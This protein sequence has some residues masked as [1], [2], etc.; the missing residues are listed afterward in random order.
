MVFLTKLLAFFQELFGSM[1]G[2]SSPEFKKKQAFK[3]LK[4]LIRQVDPPLYRFDGYLLP[5]FPASLQQVY[6]FLVPIKEI[7]DKTIG[8]SEE[9]V[10]CR[11]VDFLIELSLPKE[12]R[13][14]AESLSLQARMDSLI[15]SKLDPERV[16]EE[17]A[18]K[19]NAY[20][21]YIDSSSMKNVDIVITKM[22]CLKDL[23]EFDFNRFF[24]AFDPAFQAH[25]GKT[26][27]VDSPQFK[28]V[29]VTEVIPDLLDLYYLLH[30]LDLNQGVANILVLL[31]AQK[32][33]T[34]PIEENTIRMNKLF[35]AVCWIFQNKITKTNLLAIIRLAKG[36][37]L[38]EPTL[39]D[40]KTQF[41]VDYKKRHTDVF[42]LNSKK[43]LQEKQE[44]EIK[45]QIKEI[46]GTEDLET[47]SGYNEQ[48]NELL[49]EFTPFFLEWIQPLHII[50]TFAIRFF[51]ARFKQIIH[52][53]I[54]EGYF[55]NRA[56]QGTISS[57]F[58]YC[59]SI[60]Q[61][62]SEFEH[63]FEENQPCSIKILTGYITELEKGLDFEKP[64]RK[65]VDNMNEHAKVV[66]Q[67][68]V[69]GYAEI[70]GFAQL[71]IEDYKKT[72]PEYITNMRV[73]ANLAKNNESYN[74]LEKEIG[75][76][77]NFLD[78]MKK[79]AIVE[80]IPSTFFE[81]SSKAEN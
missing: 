25:I 37:P 61:R 69:S 59:E 24:S 52:S 7:F 63:L 47:I 20:I 81:K 66:V 26:T 60:P 48:T 64:L 3:E 35:Q 53:V 5:S 4:N 15:R 74:F 70:F 73:L 1:L 2:A 68:A 32:N 51:N 54:V 43:M 33:N 29:E 12:Q 34:A 31:E 16:I 17:Q 72:N 55:T 46:F 21:K 6:V 30:R 22:F 36:D 44:N 40:Q 80:V 56:M 67:K 38:Y 13:L 41:L 8:S 58:F 57:A 71:I 76:Y 27:T 19:F 65:M 75:V 78:I 77:R 79:Y 28:Q 9:R 49:E 18:K 14:I 11:Y 50:K 45:K 23:C 62:I 39:P 42:H 10:V